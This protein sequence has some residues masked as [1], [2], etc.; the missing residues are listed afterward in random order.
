MRS[1]TRLPRETR[2]YPLDALSLFSGGMGERLKPPA[3]G[4]GNPGQSVQRRNRDSGVQIPLPPPKLLSKIEPA[5]VA[6]LSPLLGYC[7]GFR[8]IFLG[9]FQYGDLHFGHTLGSPLVL[10]RGIHS[11][12]QR[13]HLYPFALIVTIAIQT[14][15]IP[16]R[17]IAS[18]GI[19]TGNFLDKYIPN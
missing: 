3:C 7:K 10:L 1:P 8:T 11:W 19:F 16:E 15:N 12:G 9:L 6:R 18:R 13:V 4:A 5:R 14:N 2:L 17:N